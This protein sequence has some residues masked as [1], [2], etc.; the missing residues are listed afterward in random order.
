MMS[1]VPSVHSAVV[2]RAAILQRA[3]RPEIPEARPAAARRPRRLSDAPW[4]V[5]C[6]FILMGVS[7]GYVLVHLAHH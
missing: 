5:I 4:D 1:P 3:A 7:L 6:L 2:H